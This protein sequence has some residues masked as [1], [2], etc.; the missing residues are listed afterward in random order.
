MV[1]VH[2]A[3]KFLNSCVCL[4][5]YRNKYGQPLITKRFVF[6]NRP[7]IK[8]PSLH[9]FLLKIMHLRAFGGCFDF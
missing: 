5:C 6:Y 2:N 7:I 3:E 8:C 1:A 9:R 4:L